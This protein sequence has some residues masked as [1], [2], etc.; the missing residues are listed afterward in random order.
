M[1]GVVGG[2][3]LGQQILELK[4]TVLPAHAGDVDIAGA[5]WYGG[6]VLLPWGAVAPEPIAPP[7]VHLP[8]LDGSVSGRSAR[9]M[10]VYDRLDFKDAG[11]LPFRLLLPPPQL[12][13]VAF[14]QVVVLRNLAGDVISASTVGWAR[15]PEKAALVDAVSLTALTAVPKPV[16]VWPGGR[17]GI[18]L[19]E[20]NKVGWT[21]SPGLTARCGQSETVLW[22]SDGVLH[23]LEVK[24]GY[25]SIPTRDL[26]QNLRLADGRS[27]EN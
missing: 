17:P 24:P 10:P 20:W 25:V 21:P 23:Q 6:F 13:E 7:K 15:D 26:V 1:V 22:V 27:K 2:F 11:R 8:Q 19:I 5:E 16:P 18:G 4:S 9:G 3:A 12:G 14:D